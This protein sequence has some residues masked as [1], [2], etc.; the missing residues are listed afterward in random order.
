VFD[1][2]QEPL[3]ARPADGDVL[4]TVTY[5]SDGLV[6]GR[7]DLLAATPVGTAGQ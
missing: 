4:G 2:P 1:L 6:L 5:R 3:A 7:V